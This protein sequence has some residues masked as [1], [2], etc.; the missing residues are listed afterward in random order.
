MRTSTKPI[1]TGCQ[2]TIK[3]FFMNVLF[4]F[5]PL[6]YRFVLTFL[7]GLLLQTACYAQ[8]D[9][10]KQSSPAAI[11]SPAESIRPGINKKFL[12]PELKVEDWVKLFEVESREVFSARNNLL[13]ALD[14]KPEMHV[15]DIGAGTGLF[16]TL[17]ADQV[18]PKGC[19][20][21]VEISLPFLKHLRDLAREHQQQQVIPVLCDEDSVRLP[22]QT[23]DVAFTCDV[24]HH[25]EYPQ[26][27]LKTIL[28]ALKPGG[29]FVVVDFEKIPGVTREWILGHV[30][31]DKQ[32]VKKE[33]EQAGF[34]FVEQKKVAGFQENYVLVFRKPAR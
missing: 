3:V 2:F 27:T 5:D 34:E 12:D 33:I 22:Y 29:R 26:A 23:I 16:T 11:A 13:D 24:Y 19:V 8:D 20:Y 4:K 7:V 28:S 9:Q 18:G 21:A 1:E 6:L 17:F 10:P 14:L 15:A 31:A 25:F 32:T 30:R